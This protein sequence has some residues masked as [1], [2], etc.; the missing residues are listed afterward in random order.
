MF[1]TIGSPDTVKALVGSSEVPLAA[2]DLPSGRLLAANPALA[3]ALGSTVGMLTGSSSLD[4]LAPADR[5]AAR[6]A[7]QALG[8]GELSGYQAIRRF[9]HPRDPDRVFSVWVSV[10]DVGG[11]RVGLAAVVPFAEYDNQFR[12]LPPVSKVPE[13][14]NAVLGTVDSS[15][16]IDRISQDVAP[17]LGLSPE[18][19]AGQPVLGVI[20]PADLPA[21]LAAVE[22]ARRGERAVRLALRLSVRSRDWAPVTVV[23]APLA[24]GDPPPLAFAL[25]RDDAAADP[26]GPEDS[27]RE[28]Q[29]EAHVLRIADELHAAGLI[30]RLARLPVL[31]EQPQLGRLSSREWAVLA[32]LLDG[33]RIAAI[34]ADLLVSPGTVRGHLSSIYAKLGVRSQAELI[35]LVRPRISRDRP[36][37]SRA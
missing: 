8:D 26:P 21:F 12:A 36:P 11:A 14:G 10:V 20:H 24:P 6:L 4:W 35:R 28:M 25:I 32:R 18:Q 30:P 1:M 33:Q 27:T 29:L 34:A 5:P 37:A 31:T 23:L 9:A 13:P 16:R 22:H 2:V 19:C 7:F 15:W 17:L 3:D